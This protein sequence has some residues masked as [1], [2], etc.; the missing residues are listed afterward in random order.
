MQSQVSLKEGS[1]GRLEDATLLALKTEEGA[2]SQGTQQ[3]RSSSWKSQ[4]N[5]LSTKASQRSR[6]LTVRK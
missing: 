3:C 6:V 5:R 2:M 4:D 1:R